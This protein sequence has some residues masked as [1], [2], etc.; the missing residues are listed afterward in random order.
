MGLGLAVCRTI[1]RAHRGRLWATNNADR[2]ATIHF[3][4]PA[5]TADL[6]EAEHPARGRIDVSLA[7]EP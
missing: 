6:P 3:T 2:G 4:V 7:A 5:T 1:V